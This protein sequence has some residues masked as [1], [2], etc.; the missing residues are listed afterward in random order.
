[1]CISPL[2][3]THTSCKGSMNSRT[4]MPKRRTMHAE[5]RPPNP[6][7][8]PSL[9]KPATL[10]PRLFPRRHLRNA[11]ARPL[12]TKRLH[13]PIA[14]CN[15]DTPCTN[16]ISNRPTAS[17]TMRPTHWKKSEHISRS[18]PFLCRHRILFCAASWH[19]SKYSEYA[20]LRAYS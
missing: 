1:M 17:Q 11:S 8:P 16:P 10:P 19:G 4:P 6:T 13:L 5:R 9:S 12:Q 15:R 7:P 3:L 20:L 2:H 18:P 14:P